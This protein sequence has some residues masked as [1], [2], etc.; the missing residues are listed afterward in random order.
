MSYLAIL[1]F[2]LLSGLSFAQDPNSGSIT[3]PTCNPTLVHGKNTRLGWTLNSY[4]Q[5]PCH[6]AAILLST[7]NGS[8]MSIS[9]VFST[10][11]SRHHLP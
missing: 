2:L 7:C 10:S 11:G 9:L 6:V 1:T 3:Y 8:S 5:D 4:G